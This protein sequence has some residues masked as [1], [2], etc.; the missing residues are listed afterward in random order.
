MQSC[1]PQTVLGHE[2]PFALQFSIFMPNRVGQFC[3]LLGSLSQND[4][5]LLGVSVVDSTDWAV[6]RIIGSDPGHTREVLRRGSYNFTESEVLLVELEQSETLQ[7][8]CQCLLQAEINVH[9]AYALTIQNHN[10]PVIALHV[11]DHILACQILTRHAFVLLGQED[12]ADP[13][14]DNDK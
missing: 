3:D 9:F 14:R 8:A 1:P 10:H 2:E 4:I 12:L 13:G 5:E 6:L 11:D 7:R